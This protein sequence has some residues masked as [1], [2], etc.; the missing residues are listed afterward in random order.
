[1]LKILETFESHPFLARL[2]SHHRVALAS[3]AQPF[4]YQRG[5]FLTKEG[6]S[7]D[8]FFLIQSGVVGIESQEGIK[9]DV[10]QVQKL[11]P[12][13]VIGWSWLAEPHIWQFSCKA[14]DEVRGVKFDGAWLRHLC[15]NNSELGFQL[16]KQLLFVISNRLKAMRNAYG[17]LLSAHQLS[18]Q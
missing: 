14:L 3:G 16:V 18:D 9:G 6:Q 17:L 15:E 1:M 13:D 10:V 5:E 7:A 4:H 8:H 2:N 12:G 11:G